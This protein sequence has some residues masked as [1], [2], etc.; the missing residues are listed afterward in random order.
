MLKRVKSVVYTFD[1]AGA[2]SNIVSELQLKKPDPHRLERAE[3]SKP[4]HDAKMVSGI[5]FR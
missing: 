4:P 5:Y 3:F 1:K 2:I